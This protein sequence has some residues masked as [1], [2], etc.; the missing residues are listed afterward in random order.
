MPQAQSAAVTMS[1]AI[2]PAQKARSACR[3]RMTW[4]RAIWSVNPLGAIAARISA[5]KSRRRR[6]TTKLSAARTTKTISIA[7]EVRGRFTG[8]LRGTTVRAHSS[9]SSWEAGPGLGLLSVF[10]L[11]GIEQKGTE[12]TKEGDDAA[13]RRISGHRL[14]GIEDR[15]RP[16]GKGFARRRMLSY[17]ERRFREAGLGFTTFTCGATTA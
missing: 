11:E 7:I 6:A 9:I 12:E 4:T 14:R 10:N 5:S 3:L 15:M 8:W 17:D 1:P 13:G 16:T 2:N